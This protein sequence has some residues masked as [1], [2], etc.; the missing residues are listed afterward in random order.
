MENIL[1]ICL[2]AI[3]CVMCI[4]NI[5]LLI[6]MIIKTIKEYKSDKEY[7]KLRKQQLK[8]MNDF[9]KQRVLVAECKYIK[10]EEQSEQKENK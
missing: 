1:E 6:I 2:K 5:T 10:N 3:L 9:F 4:L 7:D 8:E